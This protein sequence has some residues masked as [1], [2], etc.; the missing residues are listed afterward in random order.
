MTTSK[1]KVSKI[2]DEFICPLTLDIMI[3]PVVDVYGHNFEKEAILA[4]IDKGN[5]TCPLTRKDLRPSSM[6]SDTRLRSRI[7]EWKQMQ[8]GSTISSSAS[9]SSKVGSACNALSA[10][11][12]GPV[13][14]A[15]DTNHGGLIVDLSSSKQI[16]EMKHDYNI[17]HHYSC[18]MEWGLQQ[19]QL[20][21]SRNEN[22]VES[23]ILATLIRRNLTHEQL[24]TIDSLLN[25]SEKAGETRNSERA[26]RN[27]PSSTWM[28]DKKRGNMFRMFR[29]LGF[30]PHSKPQN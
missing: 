11:N 4:W 8:R 10:R 22:S 28:G 14:L 29:Q 20:E 26:N 13:G 12:N 25:D 17:P 30:S 1:T 21:L 27:P 15:I 24:E 7:E 19:L 9:S 18:G 2:P 23:K 16:P 3:D 6:V 5:T